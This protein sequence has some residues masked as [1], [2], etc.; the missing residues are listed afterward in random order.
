MAIV[1]PVSPAVDQEFFAAGHAFRW[2]GSL[3]RR[4]YYAIIDAGFHN[5]SVTDSYLFADG[6]TP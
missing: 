1:F 2:D 3:W 6:G 5:T 4:I